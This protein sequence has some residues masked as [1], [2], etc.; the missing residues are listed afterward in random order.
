MLP[1]LAP[2]AG[3]MWCTET[4]LKPLVENSSSAA[5]RMASRM[6]GLRIFSLSGLVMT[7]VRM[8]KL[9]G[10]VNNNL[11]QLYEELSQGKRPYKTAIYGTHL[12][13]GFSA[14]MA[15]AW[16]GHPRL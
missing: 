10:P 4:A 5:A 8:Y 9:D 15:G 13:T 1:V 16:P 11:S 12:T 6:F 2:A 14:V 3:E 7:F